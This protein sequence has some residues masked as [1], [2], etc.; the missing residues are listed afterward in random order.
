MKGI[1]RITGGES[2]WQFLS[3]Y[4]LSIFGLKIGSLKIY[5]RKNRFYFRLKILATRYSLLITLF[6][7]EARESSVPK[8]NC[9][10]SERFSVGS[11]GSSSGSSGPC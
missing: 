8:T 6:Y 7:E 3:Q 4:V 5:F 2:K 10:R 11:S 1:K 9:E